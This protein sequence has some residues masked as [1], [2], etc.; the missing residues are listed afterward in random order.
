[1]TLQTIVFQNRINILTEI[2][3]VS[4]LQRAG[5][6]ERHENNPFYANCTPNGLS[7]VK[8]YHHKLLL[9][10]GTVK[11]SVFCGTS[12]AH[13]FSDQLRVDLQFLESALEVTGY[14]VKIL[15]V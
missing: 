6:Q 2:D 4:R 3:F 8:T 9:F 11:N 1:M 5:N 15:L 12:N 7:E 10:G 14:H 13:Y